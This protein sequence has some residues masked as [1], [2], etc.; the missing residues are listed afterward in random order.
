MTARFTEAEVIAATGAVAV[1]P[2]S[3]VFEGVLTDTR[4]L[5]PGALYVALKG[6][7]FDGHDFLGEAASSGAA[8]ALVRRGTGAA[9]PGFSL[10]LYEVEDTLA[11]LG[12]LARFH[13]ERFRIPIGAVAGSNGKTTAKE[14]VAAILRTRGEALASEGNFNNEIGVPL[15]LFRLGPEHTSGVLELGMSTPGELGRI[16]RIARPDAGVLTVIAAE[17]IETLK[18]LDG[19]ANAEG[20]LFRNLPKGA[21]AV[22]NMDDP[23][24]VR[25]AERCLERL[26]FGRSKQADVRLASVR[27]LGA[28]GLEVFFE[29]GRE[30]GSCRLAFVGEHNAINAAAAFALARALGF[31]FDECLSGLSAARPYVHRSRV[32]EGAPGGITILDDCYNANPLSMEAALKTLADLRGTGRA[33]AVLGDMLELGVLEEAEHRALGRKAAA[34]KLGLVAFFGPR[35]LLSFEESGLSASAAHFVEIEPLL[36]WL[37]PRLR[38]GDTVLVKGSRG[39]KLERVVDALVAG[40]REVP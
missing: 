3:G 7:R 27:S 16:T 8:G 14:M 5:V 37:R 31:S 23:R 21:T 40:E 2:A 20:E 4:T 34:A 32:I 15:T 12:A 30:K 38:P 33:V 19:V 28:S 10:P 24:I 11:A 22:V 17:H 13:R 36:G 35:S 9:Q 1:R 18:D 26:T 39:M 29:E 6:E 25:E